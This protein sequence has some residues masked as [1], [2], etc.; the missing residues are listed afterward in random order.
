MY[1]IYQIIQSSYSYNR[2][3]SIEYDKYKS[4]WVFEKKLFTWFPKSLAWSFFLFKSTFF[5]KYERSAYDL[6]NDLP[7]AVK[8]KYQELGHSEFI[9]SSLTKVWWHGKGPF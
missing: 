3:Y 8:A 6:V 9:K 1:Y 4:R 7:G 5:K 2:Y